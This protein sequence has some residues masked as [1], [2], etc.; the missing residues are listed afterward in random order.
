MKQP[1]KEQ[2]LQ[3]NEWIR[4]QGKLPHLVR[5]AA[6]SITRTTNVF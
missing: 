1:T 2:R 4:K 6:G 5:I 3:I